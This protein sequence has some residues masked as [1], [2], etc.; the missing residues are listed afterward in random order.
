MFYHDRDKA[1]TTFKWADLL[2]GNTMLVMYPE[3]KTF[4]DG[5][6]GVR[7]GDSGVRHSVKCALQEVI[8]YA[9]KIEARE[10]SC[11]GCGAEGRG[12]L[13]KCARCRTCRVLRKACQQQ[14]W[15]AA[16]GTAAGACAYSAEQL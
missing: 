3:T 15:S 8:G 14:D 5:T 13:R 7:Q 11:W 12:G 2:L 9:D 1:P 10:Y 6:Q 16:Q 4:M